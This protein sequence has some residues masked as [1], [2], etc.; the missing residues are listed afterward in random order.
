MAPRGL[1]TVRFT[2]AAVARPCGPGRGVLLEG[3]ERGDGVLVWLRAADSVAPGEYDYLPRGDTVAPRGAVAAVRY[4]RGDVSH[5]FTLDSGRVVVTEWGDRVSAHLSGSGLEPLAAERV[6][7]GA[8]FVRVP[9]D[10][11][12]VS[13]GTAP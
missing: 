5:G 1:D 9:F 13:C 12:R 6:D 10:A 7:L 11:G 8:T 4:M 3:V 2:T